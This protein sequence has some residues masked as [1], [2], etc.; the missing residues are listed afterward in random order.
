MGCWISGTVLHPI[1]RYTGR[2]G[3][4]LMETARELYLRML[5]DGKAPEIAAAPEAKPRRNL[6]READYDSSYR[7]GA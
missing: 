1:R 4:S 7:T 6:E 3:D 5:A 2:S